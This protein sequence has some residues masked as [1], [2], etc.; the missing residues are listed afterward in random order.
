MTKL[1]EIDIK[2]RQYNIEALVRE[3]LSLAVEQ[4]IQQ[5]VE[6]QLGGYVKRAVAARMAA[7]VAD[8]GMT[9]WLDELVGTVWADQRPHVKRELARM[10][11]NAVDY[12][13]PT[14]SVSV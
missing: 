5:A 1:F 9:A 11:N 14:D 4:C 12:F 13:K 7:L 10:A 3:K 6:D 2:P 8:E